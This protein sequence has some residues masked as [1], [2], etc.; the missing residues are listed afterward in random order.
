MVLAR[1]L[2]VDTTLLE[3]ETPLL[4][5][6]EQ[7]HKVEVLQSASLQYNNDNFN[8]RLLHYFQNEDDA[9]RRMFLTTTQEHA[10]ASGAFSSLGTED[11][12]ILSKTL[13]SNT[14]PLINRVDNVAVVFGCGEDFGTTDAPPHEEGALCVS[15]VATG[16]CIRYS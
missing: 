7:A 16:Q 3:F 14:E 5:F 12:Y 13:P 1:W 9:S 10:L 4:G 2:R 8:E 6:Y 15:M 11:G